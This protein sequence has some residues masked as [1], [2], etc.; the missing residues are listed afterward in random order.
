MGVPIII[1]LI[2]LSIILNEE[3]K[4]MISEENIIEMKNFEDI[5]TQ[6]IK[7]DE[8]IFLEIEEKYNEIVE[9]NLEN[10]YNIRERE[11]QKSGPFSID[12][13]EY[14]LGEKIFLVIQGL[15]LNEKGQVSILKP[16]NQTH[17]SVWMTFPFDGKISES[18]NVYFEPKLLKLQEICDK[19]DLLGNWVMVFRNTDYEN[20]RFKIIDSIVPG[21][22]ELFNTP[23]C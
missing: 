6:E 13:K 10:E 5:E 21:D 2:G 3:E 9:K 7:T 4:D 14:A 23:V 16:L 17:Y 12:R 8:E 15:Q 1:S 19:N 20:I 22:E 11:W 18:F